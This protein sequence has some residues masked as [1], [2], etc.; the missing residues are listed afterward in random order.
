M[1]TFPEVL[2]VVIEPLFL[3]TD[4]QFQFCVPS[5]AVPIKVTFGPLPLS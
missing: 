2:V 4:V 5:D 3:E 1:F